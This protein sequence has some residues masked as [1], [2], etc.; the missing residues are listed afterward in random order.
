MYE[1]YTDYVTLIYIPSEGLVDIIIR[2]AFPDMWTYSM[3]EL[4]LG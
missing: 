3:T 4:S 2:E 1:R